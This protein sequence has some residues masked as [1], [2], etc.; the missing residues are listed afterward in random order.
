[1]KL[2]VSDLAWTNEEETA[3]A[4]AL[5][6]LGV[7]YI[8]LA[9][10]KKWPD[11][12]QAPAAE[13]TNLRAFWK[14]HGFEIVALQAIL[15][16]HPELT[17]F[18]SPQTRSKTL[19]YLEASFQLASDLGAKILVFGSPKN[20]L[21]GELTQE[22]AFDI[23]TDFFAEAGRRAAKTGVELCI[24]PNAT[25]YGCDFITTSAEGDELVR[26][27]NSPGFGLHLDTGCMAMASDSPANVV[28]YPPDHFHISAPFLGPVEPQAAEYKAFASSL[29]EIDY[30]GFVSIEMK[31][32][33]LGNI[34][35]TVSAVKLSQQIFTG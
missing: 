14:D 26:R 29:K 23:A 1:M 11:L 22:K 30:Q 10:T 19:D 6:R 18:K 25:Q 12:D 33:A 4:A 21:I 35:R 8:E 24:E 13:V 16:G 17:I 27:V 5:S 2:A 20:R 7:K 32:A 31:P 28:K 34:E 3:A 9:P 15:F